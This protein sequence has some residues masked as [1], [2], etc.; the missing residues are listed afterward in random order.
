[1]QFLKHPKSLVSKKGE[2]NARLIISLLLIVII[3]DILTT[4][5]ASPN[6]EKE[7]NFVVSL[8]GGDWL[9]IFFK[10]VLVFF[11]TSTIFYYTRFE[12][13]KLNISIKVKR[14]LGIIAS[15]FIIVSIVSRFFSSVQN[16]LYGAYYNF[17]GKNIFSR[18]GYEW[19]IIN[20]ELTQ[21]L[22]ISLSHPTLIIKDL[23]II[24][25]AIF[26]AYRYTITFKK[27]MEI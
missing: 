11:F 4:H 3:I 22:G 18:V 9:H 19:S 25:I 2:I 8:L 20:R 7:N 1:M 6:L 26:I 5:F 10:D 12:N 14:V 15:I 27:E 17:N 23:T 13:N 24:V 16:F 21:F